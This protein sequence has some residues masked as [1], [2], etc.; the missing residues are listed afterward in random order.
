[1]VNF[2]QWAVDGFVGAGVSDSDYGAGYDYV[3]VY[4]YILDPGYG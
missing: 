2:P 1:M 3:Y 4:D